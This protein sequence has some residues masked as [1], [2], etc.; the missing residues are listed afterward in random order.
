M[1]LQASDGGHERLTV[2]SVA[3]GFNH[4]S[5]LGADIPKNIFAARYG[6]LGS[7]RFQKEI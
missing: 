7:S 3:G 2:A 1:S 6:F 4:Q 5:T